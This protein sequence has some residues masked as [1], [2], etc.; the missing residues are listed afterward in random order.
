[1]PIILLISIIDSIINIHIYIIVILILILSLLNIPSSS[2]SSLLLIIIL[3]S[4]GKAKTYSII[5][6]LIITKKIT[7]RA[8]RAISSSRTTTLTIASRY[9]SLL[10][11]YPTNTSSKSYYRSIRQSSRIRIAI[12]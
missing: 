6:D 4:L 2:Y 12:A 5:R 7:I 10:V 1:M 11:T 3:N 8:S 9:T